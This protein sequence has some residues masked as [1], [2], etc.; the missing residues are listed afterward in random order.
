MSDRFW[1]AACVLLLWVPPF[2]IVLC[3]LLKDPH[4]DR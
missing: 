4:R 1:L 2:A 3:S